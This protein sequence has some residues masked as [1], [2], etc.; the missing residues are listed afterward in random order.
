[1][2]DAIDGLDLLVRQMLEEHL[3][4][5]PFRIPDQLPMGAEELLHPSPLVKPSV[6]EA[7]IAKVK[8][9]AIMKKPVIGF[10]RHYPRA[11]HMPC[12]SSP[13]GIPRLSRWPEPV[14]IQREPS[15]YPPGVLRSDDAFAVGIGHIQGEFLAIH[16]FREGNARTI[17]LVTDLL[18]VQTGRLPLQYNMSDAGRTRYIDAAKAALV[19]NYE[20]MAAVIRDAVAATR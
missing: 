20:P 4:R 9:H 17:K 8:C 11:L 3:L 10:E 12:F 15:G 14:R 19:K 13:R 16:P 7:V 1:M 2:G 6:I 18:A 5:L